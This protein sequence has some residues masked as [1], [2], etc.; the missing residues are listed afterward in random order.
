MSPNLLHN[1][2]TTF[3]FENNQASDIEEPSSEEETCDTDS[4]AGV[5][6]KQLLE[7]LTNFG[8]LHS[9]PNLHYAYKALLTIPTS[10]A[11]AERAFSKVI[12]FL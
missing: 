9:F 2:E 8:I 1:N 6:T 10:S 11:S 5:D 3:L 7:V 12:V 4:S